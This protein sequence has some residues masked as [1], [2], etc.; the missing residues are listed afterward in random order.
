MSTPNPGQ[1]IVIQYHLLRT[2]S[3]FN[4]PPS[5]STSRGNKTG[6]DTNNSTGMAL[7]NQKNATSRPHPPQV[8]FRLCRLLQFFFIFFAPII[9]W[10]SRPVQ[11][12]YSSVSA[13]RLW[14]I[15]SKATSSI[16]CSILGL[17][18]RRSNGTGYRSVEKSALTRPW[19]VAMSALCSGTRNW[20]RILQPVVMPSE[21]P[22]WAYGRTAKPAIASRSLQ[23]KLT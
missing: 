20:S 12:T 15:G 22:P 4:L 2:E 9:H 5:R 16:P 10:P 8:F 13:S 3:C 17:G 11:F 23:N 14:A 19:R 18:R 1:R 6:T 21:L 7:S